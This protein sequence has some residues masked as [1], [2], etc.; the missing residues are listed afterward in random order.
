MQAQAAC[1]G[2]NGDGAA[3]SSPAISRENA[4]EDV[5]SITRLPNY[6][7]LRVGWGKILSGE[8]ARPADT[9]LRSRKDKNGKAHDRR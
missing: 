4:A 6:P 8:T 5:L 7:A 9:V 2:M 1:F 3:P